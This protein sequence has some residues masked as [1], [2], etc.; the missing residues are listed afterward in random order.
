MM[1]QKSYWIIYKVIKNKKWYYA[2][3]DGDGYPVMTL[4]KSD[5][6]RF[7]D[8]NKVNIDK[9]KSYDLI[10]DGSWQIMEVKKF[11]NTGGDTMQKVIITIEDGMLTGVYTD[12]DPIDVELVDYDNINMGDDDTGAKELEAAI[13]AGT[14]KSCY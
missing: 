2:G 3:D 10:K 9:L 8:I 6:A 1:N 11:D 12:G 13:K 4:Y 14:V 7:N 5:A